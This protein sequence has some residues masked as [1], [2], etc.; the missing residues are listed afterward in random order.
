MERFTEGAAAAAAA[1]ADAAAAAATT[2]AVAG[3]LGTRRRA[4]RQSVSHRPT[5]LR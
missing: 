1:D 2:A 5:V 3:V 4:A